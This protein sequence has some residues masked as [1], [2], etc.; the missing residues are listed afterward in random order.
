MNW[1]EERQQYEEHT[2]KIIGG[3]IKRRFR[4]NIPKTLLA[5][6]LHKQWNLTYSSAQQAITFQIEN[7]HHWWL[8]LPDIINQKAKSGN[9]KETVGHIS[10][11]RMSDYLSAIGYNEYESREIFE[12]L[13][14]PC[15][16]L[17]YTKSNVRPLVKTDNEEIIRKSGN[18]H[19]SLEGLGDFLW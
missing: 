18:S 16:G 19:D 13:A 8:T 6:H 10:S 9:K 5:E 14:L 4:N 12:Q 1:F 15:K 17:T 3:T 2:K 7:D 11:K